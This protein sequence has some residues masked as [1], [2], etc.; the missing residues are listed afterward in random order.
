MTQFFNKALDR[1]QLGLYIICLVNS[2]AFS[3]VINGIQ[4]MF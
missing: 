4:C 3:S 1:T 2:P